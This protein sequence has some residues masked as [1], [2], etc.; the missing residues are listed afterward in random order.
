[1]L[2]NA[3][4]P[5]ILAGAFHLLVGNAIVGACEGALFAEM[6]KVRRGRAVIAFVLANYASAWLG[7]MWLFSPDQQL[8]ANITIANLR[9]MLFVQLAAAFVLTVLVEFP[10]V[11]LCRSCSPA[12]SGTA[13]KKLPVGRAGRIHLKVQLWSYCAL[14]LFYAFVS[15]S[16]ALF[17]T[18]VGASELLPGNCRILVLSRDAK[19]VL[20]YGPSGESKVVTNVESGR[21]TDR[22]MLDPSGKLILARRSGTSGQRT[23]QMIE[24]DIPI[25]FLPRTESGLSYQ[26]FEHTWARRNSFISKEGH[27]E[28]FGD[29]WGRGLQARKGSRHLSFGFSS[30]LLGWVC[31]EVTRL[32]NGVALFR[33]GPDQVCLFDPDT[34]RAA[35]LGRGRSVV[36]IL[37]STAH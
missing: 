28:F 5:L 23:V 4:S 26:S 3:G 30:P 37:T 6:A 13:S 20:Q 1:M 9:S 12:L 16:S 7:V 2:A 34:N 35:L 15:Q 32:P 25:E 33:L 27:W 14:S 18:G 31:D 17:A 29:V 22:L 11:L 8:W 24:A 36:P 21:M 19:S 10:F